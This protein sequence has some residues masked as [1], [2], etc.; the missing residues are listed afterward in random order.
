MKK[1]SMQDRDAIKGRGYEKF[2]RA[3]EYEKIKNCQESST[4]T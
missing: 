2:L 1:K 4:L 3:V